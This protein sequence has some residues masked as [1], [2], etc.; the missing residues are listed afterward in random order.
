MLA[1]TASKV[2]WRCRFFLAF[3][4]ARCFPYQAKIE[5]LAPSN[6]AVSDVAFAS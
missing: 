1:M 6:T 2:Q 5:I 4:E 3:S